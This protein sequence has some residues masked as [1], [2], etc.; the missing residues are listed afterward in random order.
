MNNSLKTLLTVVLFGASSLFADVATSI[1]PSQL[2]PV[3]KEAYDA[4]NA[5]VNEHKVQTENMHKALEAKRAERDEH[6]AELHSKASSMKAQAHDH[7]KAEQ[8]N[9]E[10]ARL[11]KD[12]TEHVARLHHLMNSYS[13]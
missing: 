4:H 13:K 3:T 2:N 5:L 12:L 11:H 8:L 10:C 1:Q 7:K 9:N 6:N